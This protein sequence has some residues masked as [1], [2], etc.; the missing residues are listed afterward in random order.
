MIKLIIADDERLIR[1]GLKTII[2]WKSLGFEIVADAR[3]GEECLEKLNTLKPEVC[4]IDI[5]M[6]G[7][8]GLEVIKEVRS[9]G[10]LQ[11]SL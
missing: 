1:E 4:I 8:S 10:L 5:R 6:P 3:D 7:K 2:N 9:M 11:K